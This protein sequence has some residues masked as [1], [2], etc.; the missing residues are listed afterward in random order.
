VNSLYPRSLTFPLA[1]VAAV[2]LFAFLLKTGTVAG[3]TLVVGLLYS[4]LAAARRNRPGSPVSPA[5][6]PDAP[7]PTR[8]EPQPCVPQYR[9]V[10]LR[11]RN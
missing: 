7:A 8:R 11:R 1:L 3:V 9:Q 5:P 10:R 6:D 4:L 2:L